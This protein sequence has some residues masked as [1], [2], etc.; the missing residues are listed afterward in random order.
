MSLP[1]HS[2]LCKPKLFMSYM[3]TVKPKQ[4]WLLPPF[5]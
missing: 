2:P 5:M 3:S 1:G 4:L